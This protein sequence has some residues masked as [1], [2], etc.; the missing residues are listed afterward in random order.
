MKFDNPSKSTLRLIQI[1]CLNFEGNPRRPDLFSTF[2]ILGF[3]AVHPL[4]EDANITGY[5]QIGG[6]VF[7]PLLP[8]ALSF[9]HAFSRSKSGI[10]SLGLRSLLSCWCSYTKNIGYKPLGDDALKG[11]LQDENL[12]SFWAEM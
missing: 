4:F 9:I 7:P 8:L 3:S 10:E 6:I 12:M 5:K 11:L 2:L 1:L